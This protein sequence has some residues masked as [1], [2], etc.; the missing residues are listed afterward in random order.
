MR[1]TQTDLS[2]AYVVELEPIEDERGFFA[3]TFCAQ[4]FAARGL[5]THFLQC[6][7]SFNL[8]RGILRGMHFQAPPHEEAKLVRCVRGRVYDVLLD[9]RPDSPTYRRWTAVELD[10]ANRRSIYIPRGFAHGFQTLE[11]QTEIFYE[12]SEPYH[13]DCARGVRWNDPAFGMH[14]PVPDPILS[15]KDRAYPDFGG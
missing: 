10:S 7:L 5:E 15:A 6:S 8:H 11:D 4:E 12:I 2:G 14:W 1:F 9:L 3:R 13:P